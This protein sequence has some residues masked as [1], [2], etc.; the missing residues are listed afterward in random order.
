MVKI[1]L[2]S[3]LLLLA[4]IYDLHVYQMDLKTAFLY[5]YI[6][7]D[8]YM[9]QREGYINSKPKHMIYKL[10][11]SRYGLKQST[12][13]WYEQIDEYLIANRFI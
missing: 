12:H 2:L 9:A 11:K 6:F 1:T 13:M 10:P 5:G 8:T 4:T 7:K 3:I